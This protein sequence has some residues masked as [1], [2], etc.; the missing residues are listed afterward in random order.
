MKFLISG[1]TGLVGS[2]LASAWRSQGHAVYTLTRHKDP[3]RPK[4]IYWLPPDRAPDLESL[5]GFDVVVHLAGEP[6]AG[7]RWTA[8]KK[9]AIQSS[10]VDSTL[11]LAQTLAA[12]KT[13]PK[14]LI[15]ASAIGYYGHRGDILLSETDAPGEGFLPEVCVAWEKAATPALTKNIR[16][17]HVRTGIVCSLQGG[18]LPMMKRPFE[19]GV[20]GPLGSGAQY[21]SWIT[22]EDLCG[23]FRFLIRDES[24]QGPVNAVA[25]NPVTNKIFS[26]QL[27][28]ALHRPCFIHVPAGLVRLALGEMADALLLSSTR[29]IPTVLQAHEYRFLFPE[30][31]GALQHLLR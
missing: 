11:L 8:K 29:V 30:L 6:I 20:G 25:P 27:A 31:R 13:P 16:V 2:T 7:G 4:A 18:A 28:A 22:L 17:V 15:C 1:A 26:E 5:E 3:D 19:W 14:T 23:I 10:R 12:L 21:M 24:I 9:A